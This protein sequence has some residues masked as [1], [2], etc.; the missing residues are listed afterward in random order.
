MSKEKEEWKW[1]P[2]DLGIKRPSNTDSYAPYTER[3]RV[4]VDLIGKAS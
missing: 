3:P 1:E 2:V 4:T